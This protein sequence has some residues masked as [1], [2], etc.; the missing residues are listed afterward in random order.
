MNSI[1]KLTEKIQTEL[2]NNVLLNTVSFG[3]ID[4]LLLDK[5]NLYPV[6]HMNLEG[7]T[8]SS[9]IAT[10]NVNI[11]LMDIVDIRDEAPTDKFKGNDNEQDVLNAMVAAASKLIAELKR[12]T[13]YRDLYQLEE[14]AN[15]EFFT[16]RFEHKIAGVSVSFAVTLQNSVDLC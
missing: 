1:Y 13:L 6:A 4:D 10:V 8:L 2:V 14:D 9:S 5:R 16:D 12:G 11:I 3:D 7:A 15:I